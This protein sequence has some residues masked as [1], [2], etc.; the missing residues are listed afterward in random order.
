MDVPFINNTQHAH[1]VPCPNVNS[2]AQHTVKVW[3]E[4]TNPIWTRGIR[5]RAG[6]SASS[7]RSKIVCILANNPAAYKHIFGGQQ[8]EPQSIA[9]STEQYGNLQYGEEV[10]LYTKI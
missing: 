2:H 6:T 9:T 10:Y 5:T 7:K 3:N 4:C 1:N 8:N